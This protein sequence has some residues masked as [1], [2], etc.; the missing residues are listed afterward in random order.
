MSILKYLD[1]AKRIDDLI[2]RKATGNAEEFARKLGVSRRALMLDLGELK[3]MGAPICYDKVCETYYY[4]GEY[5]FFFHNKETMK[6]IRGGENNL[7]FL[8]GCNTIAL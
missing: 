5:G 7:M 8:S 2:G 4:E 6:K 3:E 1:R